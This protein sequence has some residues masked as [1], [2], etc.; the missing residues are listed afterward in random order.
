MGGSF[1]PQDPPGPP[2]RSSVHVE[3][4]PLPLGISPY[5]YPPTA[6]GQFIHTATFTPAPIS[7]SMPAILARLCVIIS[8]RAAIEKYGGCSENNECNLC[9]C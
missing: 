4:T 9:Q 7:H 2:P 5:I 8:G 3:S 6:W 1:L